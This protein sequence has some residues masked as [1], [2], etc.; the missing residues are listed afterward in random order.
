MLG[1]LHDQGRNTG[2]DSVRRHIFRHDDS[3][4]DRMHFKITLPL[5]L[6]IVPCDNLSPGWYRHRPD[7]GFGI[8]G[9]KVIMRYIAPVMS[10]HF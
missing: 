2:N 4:T 6:A 1:R 3:L 10:T 8:H 5:L 7:N 9:T